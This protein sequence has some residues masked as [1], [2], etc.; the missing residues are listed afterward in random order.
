MTTFVFAQKMI[1]KIFLVANFAAVSFNLLALLFTNK[2]K[3]FHTFSKTGNHFNISGFSLDFGPSEQSLV[4]KY[5]S[6]FET[7]YQKQD[8]KKHFVQDRENMLLKKD[9]FEILLILKFQ[10]FQKDTKFK[11]SIFQFFFDITK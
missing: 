8:L 4:T 6:S 2:C 10:H 7:R 1:G 11:S 9:N 3:Y 5:H